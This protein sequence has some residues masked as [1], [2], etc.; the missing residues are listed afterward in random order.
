[1]QDCVRAIS[2]RSPMNA[3]KVEEK[4]EKDNSYGR[5]IF[6]KYSQEQKAFELQQAQELARV[7]VRKRGDGS[8]KNDGDSDSDPVGKL[9]MGAAALAIAAKNS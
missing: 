7:R 6:S 9:V 3:K 8:D 5:S 4:E 1:M 2:M